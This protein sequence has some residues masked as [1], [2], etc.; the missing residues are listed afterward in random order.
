MFIL[1]CCVSWLL[2]SPSNKF[3]TNQII[4]FTSI[5]ELNPHSPTLHITT[6]IYLPFTVH[7]TSKPCNFLITPHCILHHITFTLTWET[8]FSLLKYHLIQAPA[9]TKHIW[10]NFVM[11]DELIVWFD[12]LFLSLSL[13]STLPSHSHTL[14]LSWSIVVHPGQF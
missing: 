12:F 10:V 11:I 6:K 3:N 9:E 14:F 2:L 1:F 5:T 7:Q 4:T 8:F 13:S